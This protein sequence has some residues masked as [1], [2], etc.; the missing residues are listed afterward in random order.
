MVFRPNLR[1]LKSL[2]EGQHFLL[3]YLKTLS[4]LNPQPPPWQTYAL[5][6]ACSEGYWE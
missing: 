6:I 2:T 1:K 4:G 5:P 3:S